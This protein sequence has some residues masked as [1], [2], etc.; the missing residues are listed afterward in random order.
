MGPRW[1]LLFIIIKP[2][3]AHQTITVPARI[4][5]QTKR[6]PSYAP[7]TKYWI[8]KREC[9][10]SSCPG[11]AGGGGC[12]QFVHGR[13]HMTIDPHISTMPGRSTSGFAPT[14]QTSRV[15][16][17]KHRGCSVTRMVG[18]LHPAGSYLPGGLGHLVRTF[19]QMGDSFAWVHLFSGAS[20]SREGNGDTI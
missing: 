2:V 10:D 3:E 12:T 16:S 6:K 18:D 14:R 15:P 9:C 11:L 8:L 4:G 13:N 7:K 20:T 17:A 1:T 5:G 19:L